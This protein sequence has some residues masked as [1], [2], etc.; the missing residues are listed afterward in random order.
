MGEIRK[1]E[2]RNSTLSALLKFFVTEKSEVFAVL[3]CGSVNFEAHT[4][5]NIRSGALSRCNR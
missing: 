4:I 5:I 1:L 2:A 3:N